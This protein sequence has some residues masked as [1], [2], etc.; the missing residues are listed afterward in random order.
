MAAIIEK[1]KSK[2]KPKVEDRGPP[3]YEGFDEYYDKRVEEIAEKLGTDLEGGLREDEAR[4]RL[5]YDGP[6]EIP[7]AK[8]S[9]IKVYVAPLLNT[10]IVIYLVTATML[11]FL[12]E[13]SQTVI[14]FSILAINSGVAVVQQVRA[15]KKME[16]LQKMSALTSTV[17]RDGEK[18]EIPTA[19]LVVGDLIQLS[20]GDKV[21]ADAR[22]IN[23]VNLESN[24]ASL[25]GESV[26]VKKDES[27]SPIEGEAGDGEVPLQDQLNMVFLGS[28]IA[29]GNAR[30]IVVKTGGAT[31]IGKI[32]QKM[33]DATTG[34]IPLR[35]KV[36]NLAKYL[37]IGV[38]C[39]LIASFFYKLVVHVEQGSLTPDAVRVSLAQSIGVAMNIMPINIP[40]LTT[41]ILL[42]GVQALATRGVIIRNLAAVE[43]L[44]RVSIVCTDKTG[45]LTKNEMTV[46]KVWCDWHLYNVSGNG[47]LPEGELLEVPALEEAFSSP[48]D[49]SDV[50]KE[51]T[52]T[53]V[54]IALHPN[55]DLLLTSAVLNNNASIVE[56]R[57]KTTS[58]G[59]REEV[60]RRVIGAPTEAALIVLFEKSGL[61]LEERGEDY[62]FVKE[63][64]FD[65]AVKKMTKVYRRRG[66]YIAFVK[67][68]SEVIIPSCSSVRRGNRAVELTEE[69]R[70]EVIGNVNRFAGQGFR[71]LSLTYRELDELPKAANDDDLRTLVERDLTYLGFVCILDP[72]R[73]GVRES[74]RECESAGVT[75][76]MITGDSPVTA[77]AI[78]HDLEIHDDTELVVEGREIDSLDSES[79]LK[80]AVFAR[81][82][83]EHKSVIVKRY[84]NEFGRVVAMTGD[85]VNDALALNMADA[86]IAMGI[87]GTDVAKQAADMVITDDSFNS[88]ERGI[89]EGRGLFQK[90]RTLIF[91]YV[92]INLTE[93]AIFFGAQFIPNFEMYTFWQLTLVYVSVH[94]WP[95]FVICFDTLDKDIMKE[96]PRNGEEIITRDYFLMMIFYAVLMATGIALSYGLTYSGVI[97]VHAGNLIDGA[98][99]SKVHGTGAEYNLQKARTMGLVTLAFCET[100]MMLAMRRPNKSLL[101]SLKE[102]MF[103][104]LPGLTFTSFGIYIFVMYI[105]GLQNALYN[106]G[107][108]F[109]LMWLTA[110]DWALAFSFALPSIVGMELYRWYLRREAERMKDAEYAKVKRVRTR[111]RN[112]A[113]E[114]AIGIS[115]DDVARLE[116]ERAEK[117]KRGV[118]EL[119]KSRTPGLAEAIQ[120]EWAEDGDTGREAVVP[121]AV[122]PKKAKPRPLEEVEREMVAAV[123]ATEVIP[124]PN[125]PAAGKLEMKAKTPVKKKGKK[126]KAAK[127]KAKTP[128]KKKG[129]KKKTAKKK[130][131]TPVKKKGSK[132]KAAPVNSRS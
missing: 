116:A 54:N 37:G 26:P 78:A 3:P 68:A 11:V 10:L 6:N 41:I 45:T 108:D 112:L 32:S 14:T 49:H 73:E 109:E 91:F 57:A 20:Q 86:G 124:R 60:T 101:K 30:A 18:R 40:L 34:D 8:P 88:I 85:G 113:L 122:P 4:K 119:G 126:E 56:D 15:Q 31:E 33:Q 71:V 81:V 39:L 17:I 83:P 51:L 12:G 35:K 97:P 9:I 84:Q 90:I 114:S 106:M 22:L 89:R 69:L 66:K 105:F 5:E 102:D 79:F 65:S 82:A 2:V 128:V 16:A 94:T 123:D 23:A 21:P 76:V 50:S 29:T 80:T 7:K 48:F 115:R 120:V 64:P 38:I 127:K 99:I 1:I 52:G 75:V 93:A 129:K 13:G 19:E 103:V 61:S 121:G 58:K 62:E 25:T 96:K 111:E 63:F 132:K 53:P 36:N 130:A 110:G 42:T 27:G 46:K 28:Y 125:A 55:L 87:T 24:E 92:C 98:F 77:K 59:K 117:R 131:K 104:N 43:S 70:K 118:D 74:V 72:P 44:G 100:F 95:A 47:Y 67:G 107:F